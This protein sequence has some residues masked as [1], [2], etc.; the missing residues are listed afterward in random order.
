MTVLIPFWRAHTPDQVTYDRVPVTELP[1]A[2]TPMI[3]W[4]LWPSVTFDQVPYTEYYS[5]RGKNNS[6]EKNF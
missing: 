2:E 3:E 1:G 4:Y 5:P 6:M